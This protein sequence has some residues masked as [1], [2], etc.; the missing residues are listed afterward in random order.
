MSNGWKKWLV[1]ACI[2]AAAA[3]VIARESIVV[4]GSHWMNASAAERRAFLIGV[5]NMIVAETAYAKKNGRDGQTAGALI[6]KAVADMKLPQIEARITRWYET[7][8]GKL[9]MPVMGVVWNDM[10]K[11]K[12]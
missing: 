11:Q 9:S 10:V 12:R 6:T 7:N 5:G 1:G 2:A 8:P 4:D 3:Q